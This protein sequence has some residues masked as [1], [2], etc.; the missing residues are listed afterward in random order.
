[1]Q[2][3][4]L[5]FLWG[6]LVVVMCA[7]A[8][9]CGMSGRGRPLLGEAGRLAE[10]SS[11]SNQASSTVSGGVGARESDAA[12][13]MVLEWPPVENINPKILK[14]AEEAIDLQARFDAGGAELLPTMLTVNDPSLAANERQKCAS[15]FGKEITSSCVYT[16]TNVMARSGDGEASVVFSRATLLS[17]SGADCDQYVGCVAKSRL[18]A[19]IPVPPESGEL[20]AI[21]QHIISKP[22]PEHLK[23]PA[24]LKKLI[25]TLE[26]DAKRAREHGIASDDY[27]LNYSVLMQEK[28]IDYMKQKLEGSE[29]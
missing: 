6:G 28:I 19:K 5:K 29:G 24:M 26:E 14:A 16:L 25:G 13:H 12:N 1:M 9:M 18:G 27:K 3:S 20:T 4:D 23:D 11:A 8:L 7:G 17:G 22:V 21:S 10:R 2:R 15:A